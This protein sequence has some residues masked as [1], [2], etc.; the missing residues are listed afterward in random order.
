MSAGALV[1]KG[2]SSS[3][4]AE[5]GEPNSRRYTCMLAKIIC[6]FH[7]NQLHGARIDIMETLI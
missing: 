3:G 2:Q 1:F 7:G 6:F 4:V 5:T